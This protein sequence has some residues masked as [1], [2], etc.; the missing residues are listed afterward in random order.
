M[1]FLRRRPSELLNQ[2]GRLLLSAFPLFALP[3]F[4]RRELTA[5]DRNS[6]SEAHSGQNDRKRGQNVTYTLL[7]YLF[8]DNDVINDIVTTR[9]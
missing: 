7:G 5:F 1:N 3:A 6:A 2:T 8:R 4:C 9:E